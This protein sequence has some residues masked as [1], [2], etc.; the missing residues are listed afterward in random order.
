MHSREPVTGHLG[1][2]EP[3]HL[4][5]QCSQKSL[6]DPVGMSLGSIKEKNLTLL[7]ETELQE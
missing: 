6:T 2:A 3:R 5:G 7:K 4:K 1:A